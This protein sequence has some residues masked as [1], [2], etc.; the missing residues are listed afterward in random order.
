MI[1]KADSHHQQE[2]AFAWNRDTRVADNSQQ[3]V[4]PTKL[5]A[6]TNAR[7]QSLGTL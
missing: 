7:R 4:R 3:L 6:A 1:A 2:S 5:T